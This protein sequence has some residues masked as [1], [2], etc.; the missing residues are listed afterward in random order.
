MSNNPRSRQYCIDVV[1]ALDKHGESE[2]C[3]LFGFKP[4]TLHRILNDAKRHYGVDPNNINMDYTVLTDVPPEL[5]PVEELIAERSRKYL[6]K[7]AHKTHDTINIKLNDNMPIGIAHFGDPHIDDDGTDIVKLFRDVEVVRTT[8]G[9]YAGN[10][11]DL[12]NNWIGRLAR[13][14]GEQSTS[15]KEAWQLTVHF[16]EQLNWLYLISGNHDC[17]SGDGDP[18]NWIL[19]EGKYSKHGSR[20]NL[21]FPNG[22]NTI[23]NA[24]HKWRGHSQWN[25]AHAIAKA[26]Q[27]GWDDHILVGGHT[28]V[29]GYQVVMNP[30]TRRISHCLQVAS[31][32]VHD[33]YA[34]QLGLNDKNIF[35]CPVTIINP[36]A[37]NEQSLVHV[38][39]DVEEGAE[40][41][42]WLR[43]KYD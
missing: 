1:Q 35:N 3:N 14:Y 7:H 21:M 33:N 42:A 11:G 25:T 28:H 41:L 34:E 5:Q 6:I 9:L 13:L 10:V 32:K 36:Q 8:P 22:K 43:S 40:Y 26:S 18:L 4:V 30:A 20:I 16:V 12:Q 17:W 39:F 31:Y 27:M 2:T 24:R 15:A 38:V 19:G 29:S 37:K 23:V